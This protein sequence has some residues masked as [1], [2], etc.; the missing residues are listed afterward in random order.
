MTTAPATADITLDALDADP[1]PVFRRLRAEDPVAWVPAAG[2][3]LVTRHEDVLAVERDQRTFSSVEEGSL[4]NRA[5]G[6]T[7]LRQDGDAHRRLRAAAEGPVR[8][9]AVKERW[10]PRFRRNADALVDGLVERG[11]ADL[12]AD[13]AG[14][15]AAANLGALL[16]LPAATPADVQSWSQAFIDGCGNY[17]DDPEVW[18]RCADAVRTV[19]EAVDDAIPF[20]REHPDDSVVSSMLHAADPLTD[21]EIRTNVRIFLGGGV[22]EPRDAISVAAYGLLTHPDQRVDVLSGRTPWKAVFEEAVRWVAPIGMYPRQVVRDTELAGRRLSAGDRIGVVVSSANRDER[23]FDDPDAFDVRRP[24]GPHLAFGGGPHFCLGTWVARA[25]IAGIALPALFG[26]LPG[27]ELTDPDA[28]R[29][30]GWVFRGPLALDTTWS[31]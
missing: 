3:F 1:Y 31:S 5:I 15:L 18:Q 20:L 10:L 14:P 27:L 23:V 6:P 12:V 7:L 19:D 4:M 11:R 28:V 21:E 30:A 9:R 25:S 29:M 13:F 24:A 2:R 17:A 26:R 22:N 16:G 8:P